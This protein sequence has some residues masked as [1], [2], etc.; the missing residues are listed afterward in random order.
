MGSCPGLVG[1]TQE[2]PDDGVCG[3]KEVMNNA[4]SSGGNN[5]ASNPDLMM[6]LDTCGWNGMSLEDL[7]VIVMTEI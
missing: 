7:N 4:G 6:G 3:E 5:D 2:D 1:N